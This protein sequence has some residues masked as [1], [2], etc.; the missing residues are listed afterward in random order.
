MTPEE[1]IEDRR[2]LLAEINVLEHDL[3]ACERK[4]GKGTVDP[5]LARLA[6][7]RKNVADQ[8]YRLLAG[9]GTNH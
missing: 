9:D 1:I 4:Y 7:V 8:L 6:K 2:E 3:I 5:E